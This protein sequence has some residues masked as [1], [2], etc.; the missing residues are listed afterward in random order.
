M[1]A[2]AA[3][4]PGD[5]VVLFGTGSLAEL[6]HVYLRDDSDHEVVGFTATADRIDGSSFSGLPLV[7]FEEVVDRY[8]PGEHRMFVAVG[9]DRLNRVR[10]RFYGE[11]KSKGYELITY[12]S[13]TATVRAVALGDNCAVLDGAAIEPLATVGNDVIVW[14]GARISHHSSVGDHSFIAPGAT[15]AGHSVVGNHCFLGVN[16]TVR[17][18]IS[19]GDDC[20]IGAGATVLRD[21]PARQVLV[22]QPARP[23]AGDTGRFFD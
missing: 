1:T 8:P 23:F 19:V 21:V 7:P 4:P 2:S 5:K 13:P 16:C 9:Y 14:G 17:D 10:S 15:V 22:G 6:L 18:G 11:A 12:V 3:R 20:L